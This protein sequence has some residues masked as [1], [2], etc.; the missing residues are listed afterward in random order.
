MSISICIPVQSTGHPMLV[1]CVKNIKQTTGI[2]PIVWSD[3]DNVAVARKRITESVDT[4]YLIFVDTDAFP[5]EENWHLSMMNLA[6]KEKASIVTPIEYFAFDSEIKQI[7]RK[8]NQPYKQIEPDAP[9]MCLLVK[10][11]CGTWDTN[12]GLTNGFLGPCVEDKDFA[13]S[14]AADGGAHFIDTNVS[15]MHKDRG[16]PT[17]Q[18]WLHCHEFLCYMLVSHYIQIKWMYNNPNMFAGLG[19]VPAQGKRTLAD[20]YTIDNLLECFNPVADNVDISI[21]EKDR[22]WVDSLVDGFLHETM[23]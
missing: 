13:M 6:I 20:G 21:R 12:I 17:Y 5:V 1:D 2:D 18:D 4:E 11:G 22:E 7:T 8:K 19:R 9:G 15:V 3:G 14:I 23:I 10:R 16:M